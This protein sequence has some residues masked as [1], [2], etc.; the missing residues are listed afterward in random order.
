VVSETQGYDMDAVTRAIRR[1]SAAIRSFAKALGAIAESRAWKTLAELSAKLERHSA[2]TRKRD[3]RRVRA[4]AAA[5]QP[6]RQRGYRS[7]ACRMN[8]RLSHRQIGR[9]KKRF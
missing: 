4:E 2:A 5:H 6:W 8:Q 1:A 3:N 9:K 7:A